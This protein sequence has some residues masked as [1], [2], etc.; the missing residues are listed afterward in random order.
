MRAPGTLS[1]GARRAPKMVRR[2]THRRRG[3][4]R[5]VAPHPNRVSGHRRSLFPG[6][7]IFWDR[8]SGVEKARHIRP[9][10]GRDKIPARKPTNSALFARHREISVCMGLRGGAERTRTACQPRSRYRT[11][12]RP[13]VVRREAVINR[14]E[15]LNVKVCEEAVTLKICI[16]RAVC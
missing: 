5:L 3:S 13:L 8:D 1:R 9:I 4:Q 10:V 6:N 15:D 16:V 11:D 14:T 7:G 2:D 12:L